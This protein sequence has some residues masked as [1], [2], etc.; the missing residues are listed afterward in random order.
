MKFIHAIIFDVNE[1][2]ELKEYGV[3]FENWDDI[4]DGDYIVHCLYDVDNEHIIIHEDNTHAPVETIIETFL[5]GVRY[6][7]AVNVG[8][9]MVDNS[10]VEVINAY[11][12]VDN[13]LSY[14]KEAATLCLVE[15][16][17]VEVNN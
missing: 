1:Y 4:A 7:D 13:G 9:L 3:D 17:Y 12:V 14:D 5:E 10:D 8:G 15:G 2:N 6:R 16:A 11:I